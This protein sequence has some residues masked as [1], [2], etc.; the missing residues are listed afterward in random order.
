MVPSQWPS[1]TEP[2][3]RYRTVPISYFN[4]VV[5]FSYSY[6]WYPRPKTMDEVD[7]VT[8]LRFWQVEGPDLHGRLLKK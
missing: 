8:V 1:V 7:V 4:N 5:T 3:T 2:I 6:A